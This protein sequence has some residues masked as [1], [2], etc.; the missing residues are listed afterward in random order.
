MPMPIFSGAYADLDPEEFQ[1][2]ATDFAALDLTCCSVSTLRN[3][4]MH[5]LT[6]P[7]RS[8][9]TLV[10]Q[11]RTVP[12]GTCFWRGRVLPTDDHVLPLRTIRRT[13]DVW[14]S[15]TNLAQQM[16]LNKQGEPLLYTTLDHPHAVPAEVRLPTGSNL[17]L[18]LYQA[19]QE[20]HLNCIGL[21]ANW[22]GLDPE[23]AGAAAL[24]HEF[25]AKQFLRRVSDHGHEYYLSELVAKDLFDLPEECQDGWSY[26]SVAQAGAVNVAFRPSVA[27]SKLELTGVAL[28]RVRSDADSVTFEGLAFSDGAPTDDF[29]WHTWGSDVQRRCFPQFAQS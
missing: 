3:E 24:V 2:R 21:P 11:V 14:E 5:V 12:A 9:F 29:A 7:G 16:R 27:H 20:L 4:L 25:L 26:P 10:P 23:Q 6:P 13:A 8:G 19:S 15:P 28:R 1:R 18:I 17:A 22:D